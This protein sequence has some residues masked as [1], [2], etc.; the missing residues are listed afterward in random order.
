[1]AAA[2]HLPLIV[3]A[4]EGC[5][6]LHHFP[7]HRRFLRRGRCDGGGRSGR[8]HRRQRR[9]HFATAGLNFPDSAADDGR[10]VLA[11]VELIEA[12]DGTLGLEIIALPVV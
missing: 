10:F 2:L 12:V 4:G 9:E 5:P 8:F 6:L 7:H 3:L 11:V 1:M